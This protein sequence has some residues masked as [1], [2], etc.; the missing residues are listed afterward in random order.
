MKFLDPRFDNRP[1]MPIHVIS[2]DTFE[3]G[4][5]DALS[6]IFK[7]MLTGQKFVQNI[8]RPK[9]EVWI[10]KREYWNSV[11]YISACEKKEMCDKVTVSY[12]WRDRELAEIIGC[13]PNDVKYSPL[14]FGYDIPIENFYWTQFLLEY[15]NELPKELCVGFFD[16]ESD[17]IQARS[18]SQEPGSC[19]TTCITFLYP[20]ATPEHNVHVYTLIL[21]KDNL[22]VY[23]ESHPNYQAICDARNHYYDQVNA[24]V[25]DLPGL[26]KEFHSMFDETYGILDYHVLTFEDEIKLHKVFWEIVRRSGIDFLLAWNVPYDA[27]NLIERPLVLGYEPESIICDPDFK[28]RCCFFEEDDNIQPHKRSHKC[29]ISVKFLILC[30]MWMYAGLRVSQGKQSLRLMEVARKEIGD[31]KLNYE[32]EGSIATFMY[33][34]LRKYVIYNVKD[35][36][37][38]LGIHRATA[39]I[40]SIYDRCYNAA[41]LLPE[42]FTSTSMLTNY[43]TKF[44]YE[45]GYVMGI[46][47]NRVLPPFDYHDFINKDIAA[48]EDANQ[49]IEDDAAFDPDSMFFGEDEDGW[50]DGDGDYDDFYGE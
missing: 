2:Y 38:L 3:L 6:F 34:N 30:Q 11:R 9:Y 28:Y 43:M 44:F 32:E 18:K 40:D 49:A 25:E 5:R 36:L 26:V 7:D 20:D 19:P 10:L 4:A 8:D 23:A 31:E 29:N 22:P 45:Y 48:L 41:Q 1:L 46:N 37:L 15:G 12:H 39:D 33:K 13:Q 47:A 21:L 16:I 50:T 14:L 42:A 24:L 35:V 27:R 17:I